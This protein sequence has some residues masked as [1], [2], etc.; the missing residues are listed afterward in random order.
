MPLRWLLEQLSSKAVSSQKEQK[1]MDKIELTIGNQNYSSWSLRPWLVLRMAGIGF[2]V[3]KIPLFEAGHAERIAANTPAG[4]VPFIKHGDFL[5]WESLAICEYLAELKP[6]ARLW[7]QD[8]QSRNLARSISLEM[9]SGFFALRNE[10]PMN[11][12]RKVPGITPSKAAKKDIDRVEK[13]WLTTL[14]ATKSKGWAGDFLFGHFTIADAM[15]APVVWRFE[16]YNLCS[17]LIC[18]SYMDNMLNLEPM[19]EWAKES[20]KEEWIINY[21]ELK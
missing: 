16:N 5:L 10:F 18:R 3:K 7:P 9:V 12:R 21:A 14:A 20:A 6:Q 17:D 1:Y 15:F 2:L 8:L 13:I 4:K 11:V 19:Q